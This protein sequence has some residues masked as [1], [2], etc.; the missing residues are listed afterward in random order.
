MIRTALAAA[1]LAIAAG[2]VTAHALPSLE[3]SVGTDGAYDGND[4]SRDPT[5]VMLA[6][7]IRALPMFTLQLGLLTRPDEERGRD[8]DLDLRPMILFN[9]PLVPFH[10]RAIASVPTVFDGTKQIDVGGAVGTRFGLFGVSL[11]LEGGYLTRVVKYQDDPYGHE[12]MVEGR[13]G[14]ALE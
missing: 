11:F 9:P 13:V 6:P 4:F 2:P 10:L 1:A 3:L 12:W 8:V 7:G 14:L 5:S